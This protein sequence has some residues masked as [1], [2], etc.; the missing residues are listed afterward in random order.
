VESDALVDGVC[1][2]VRKVCGGG[3]ALIKAGGL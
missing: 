3:E 2:K 1:E